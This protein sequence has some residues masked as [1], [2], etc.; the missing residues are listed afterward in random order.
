M[1]TPRVPLNKREYYAL[2]Q[3]AK[4]RTHE[5]IAEDMGVSRVWVSSMMARVRAKLGV[6]SNLEAVALHSRA[7]TYIEVAKNLESLRREERTEDTPFDRFLT[8]EIRWLITHAGW[9]V[10][11]KPE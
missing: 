3:S 10:P 8:S 9:A 5:N 7:E 1:P 6:A 4:G 2:A 11:R